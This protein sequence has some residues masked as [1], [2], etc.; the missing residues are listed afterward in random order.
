MRV[1]AGQEYVIDGHEAGIQ[2]M[3]GGYLQLQMENHIARPIIAFR[4]YIF[5]DVLPAF[6]NLNARADQIA[7]E[8]Y[9]RIGSMPAY[10]DS[11]DMADAAEAAQDHSLS[12]YEMMVSLRQTMLN[13]MAAGLFHLAEQQLS[14]LCRDAGFAGRPLKEVKWG[15]ISDWYFEHLGLDLRQLNSWPQMDELRLVANAVKHAEGAATRQLRTLRPELFANP[16]YAEIYEEYRQHGIEPTASP[17][18]A[19]LSGEEFFVSTPLL[20]EYA[21]NT[22]AFFA[23]ITAYFKAHSGRFF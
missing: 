10:D 14:V 20:Q 16:D 6:G 18:F 4:E 23:E 12:W 19:P 1:N 2:G 3:T 8:Y 21:E 13:L 7:D 17:V 22:E 5:R 11:F 15:V 9:H